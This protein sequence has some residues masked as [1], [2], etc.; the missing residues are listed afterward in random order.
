M[1]IV[2]ADDPKMSLHKM[3]SSKQSSRLEPHFMLVPSLACPASC[4][5]CFGPHTGPVMNFSRVTAAL[6]FMGSVVSYT[7]QK[8]AR[9]TL[10][11]GEPLAAGHSVIESLMEGLHQRF[12]EDGYSVSLQ[13]NLW[14]LDDRFCE[15][16]K[17]HKVEIGT[18]LDGPMELND[19]QRGEGYFERTMAGIDRAR[20]HRLEVGCIATFTQNT[21]HRWR[22]VFD[23][24]LN[25]GLHFSI[26]PAISS[27]DKTSGLE[28]APE[29]Y[30]G[31]LC[32]MLD[33]YLLNRQRIRISSLDQ[34]CQ[35][36]AH[37]EGRVCTYRDCSDMFLVLDPLGGIYP[38]QRLAGRPEYILGTFDDNPPLS[39][40]LDSDAAQ[41][42]LGR[43]AAI[44]EKCRECPHYTYCKGGCPYNAWVGG[45][46]QTI[47]PYCESYRAV[48]EHIKLL[49]VD[50]MST[51]ENIEAIA[52]KGLAEDGHPFI[53][54]GALS[55]LTRLHSHP[56][57]TARTAKRIVAAVELARNRDIS[58]TASRLTDMSLCRTKKSGEVS[59][60]GMLEQMQSPSVLNNLY[61]HV[62]FKCQLRCTHCYVNTGDVIGEEQQEMG[63]VSMEKLIVDAV[64]C[65]FQKV[66]ITGGEPLLHPLRDEML[67]VL[68]SLRRRI[69]P[70]RLA[71][72]SNFTMPLNDSD[73]A[74][75]AGA[76]D[77]LIVSV[78]GGL[79][80]HDLRRGTGTYAKLMVNLEA[81][82]ENYNGSTNRSSGLPNAELSLATV[83][84]VSDIRSDTVGQVRMLSACLGVRHTRFRPILPLGRA[85][86]WEEPPTSEALGS[87]MDPDTII[88]SGF[89][90]VTSCGIGQNLYIE[91]SGDSFP[92]YAYHR[93]HAY[94][95]NVIL[96]GL[97]T[98][99]NSDTFNSLRCHTVDSNHKC[100]VCEVRYLCG[101]ACR[102]WGGE[103]AQR[104]LDAP[105]MECYGLR[106]RAGELYAEAVRYLSRFSSA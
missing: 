57:L 100:R 39:Q 48:F 28:L 79:E 96:N 41:K 50:E 61:L 43:E 52:R 6:N 62:T 74:L 20:S 77:Q 56:F 84:R 75:I 58:V 4:Q 37:G 11:G 45:T 93:H 7:G 26:H 23:F 82:A 90:P 34:L 12:G 103:E 18:S 102:A 46:G 14:L 92:C 2:N 76:F 87:H 24:F 85:Q 55:E 94:L 98:V 42:F 53:R 27:L 65:G 16:L 36:V 3:I 83:L 19:S 68:T 95:G 33:Y 9:V 1:S 99:I 70:A 22:E 47:D 73:L 25:N 81:Y 63:I 71:L 35:A 106:K 29:L 8:K 97:E 32:N 60:R 40:L 64:K 31:L 101:G 67:S 69:S 104:D 51:Q 5:Y 88:E 72:R 78:D 80:E 44:K 89:H 59:L 13:S 10:H 21:A 91:P 105:P 17:K 54:V 38:C 49:L 86:D 15:L 30:A 66:V